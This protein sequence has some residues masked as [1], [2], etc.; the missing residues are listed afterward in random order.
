MSRV[1]VDGA[2][3]HAAR[4]RGS[5]LKR[6]ALELAGLVAGLEIFH[7]CGV[8]GFDPKGKVVQFRKVA[9]RGDAGQF[10]SGLVG[11]LLYQRRD[12]ADR[13]HLRGTGTGED[14]RACIHFLPSAASSALNFAA[15]SGWFIAS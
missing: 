13:L 11:C 6:G 5:G 1:V 7:F 2:D 14:A 15:F 12:L 4:P 3:D 10:E 8:S 9:D